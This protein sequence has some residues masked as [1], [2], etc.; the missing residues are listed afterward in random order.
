MGR[1]ILHRIHAIK[2]IRRVFKFRRAANIIVAPIAS[3]GMKHVGINPLGLVLTTVGTDLYQLSKLTLNWLL[4]LSRILSI[5][6]NQL[7]PFLSVKKYMIRSGEYLATLA[8]SELF[9]LVA[10]RFCFDTGRSVSGM[11]ITSLVLGIFSETQQ[12]HVVFAKL[13]GC[14]KPAMW[15]LPD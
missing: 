6:V 10:S 4:F 7:T 2:S 15:L 13:N 5:S 1:D 3:G 11:R 12:L 8:V 14:F 9:V